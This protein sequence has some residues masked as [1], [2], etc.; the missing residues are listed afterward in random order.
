MAAKMETWYVPFCPLAD[1]CNKGGRRL[2]SF[3][4]EAEA[5][6]KVAWHLVNST[7]HDMPQGEA[8]EQAACCQVDQEEYEAKIPEATGGKGQQHSGK[9]GKGQQWGGGRSEPYDRWS[10]RG[11][12]QQQGS[13]LSNQALAQVAEVVSKVMTSSSS[14]AGQLVVQRPNAVLAAMTKAE[15]SARTA[16]RMARMAAGAFEEEAS[17]LRDAIEEYQQNERM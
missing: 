3:A 8:D 15:A 6:E 17:V 9:G 5:R 1:A 10:G 2:E 14:S 13:K 4:S 11:Q 16:G 12:Q 7:Y